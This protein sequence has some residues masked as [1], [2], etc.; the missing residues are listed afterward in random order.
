[1]GL[2][3][4]FI[5][6]ASTSI[7][8]ATISTGVTTR[9]LREQKYQGRVY[10]SHD[11]TAATTSPAT[12]PEATRT[13]CAPLLDPDD[14][15]DEEDVDAG[16]VDVAVEFPLPPVATP[17]VGVGTARDDTG[18]YI[19]KEDQLLYFL[20]NEERQTHPDE[21]ATGVQIV[22][23]RLDGGEE[24]LGERRRRVCLKAVD[25]L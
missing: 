24:L 10:R 22:G 5:S 21:Q 3:S 2:T 14:P 18:L 13:V 15:E 8:A 11:P 4:K 7:R 23:T 17:P 9:A 6:R 1:M 12:A 25:A 20:R 16:R 19:T